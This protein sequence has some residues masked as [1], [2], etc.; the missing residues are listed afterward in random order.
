M[1]MMAKS[2]F[3]LPKRRVASSGI[4][5]V[6]VNSGANNGAS[7]LTVSLTGTAAGMVVIAAAYP[8]YDSTIPTGYTL[9]QSLGDPN[10]Y[11]LNVAYK[12]L[13]GADASVVW[14]SNT[15]PG[16]SVGAYVL[17]GQNSTLQDATA[18]TATGGNGSGAADNASI[19]TVTNNALVIAIEGQYNGSGSPTA[20]SGYTNVASNSFSS[21][22]VGM[23]SIV[24]A[25]AGAEN[26][27]AWT[28]GSSSHWSAVTVAIRPA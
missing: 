5:I 20:P 21:S 24:K 1:F 11:C 8:M 17:S 12:I 18:T 2:A 3:L 9:I 26:P 7:N 27:A 15:G 6:N 14:P 28:T 13:T 19:T 25:T 16:L 22:S 23:A 4:T 10:G